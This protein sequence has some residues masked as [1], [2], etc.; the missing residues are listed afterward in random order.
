[1]RGHR[2]DLR[3]PAELPH[4]EPIAI[5]GGEDDQGALDLDPDARQRRQRVVAAGRDGDLRHCV[6]EGGSGHR[7]GCRRHDRQLRIVLDRQGREGERGAAARDGDRGCPRSRSSPGPAAASERC[8]PAA[9]PTP[10]R[11]PRWRH[12][13]RCRRGRTPRSRSC[14]AGGRPRG[15]Q[16]QSRKH[17]QG[18]PGGQGAGGPGHRVREHVTLDAK[19]HLVLQL[20]DEAAVLRETRRQVQRG[21]IWGVVHRSF[22]RVWV[23]IRDPWMG[24]H[25]HRCCGH[26]GRLAV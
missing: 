25:R 3:A 9:G 8:R 17:R 23:V 15:G 21:L 26:G 6:G 2:R 5:R 20:D 10:G 22:A 13:P 24:S 18:R 12:R 7:A 19:L 16:H 11:C 14:T 1:M 4:R